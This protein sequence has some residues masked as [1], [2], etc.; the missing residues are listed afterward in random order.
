MTHNLETRITNV[1]TKLGD[2]S[3]ISNE[4]VEALNASLYGEPGAEA[5]LV[6]A[7]AKLAAVPRRGRYVAHMLRLCDALLGSE[8]ELASAQQQSAPPAKESGDED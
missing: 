5:R 3:I 4:V 8:S 1:E 6:K 7:R 2:I